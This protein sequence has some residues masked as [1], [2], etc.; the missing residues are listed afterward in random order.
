[1]IP[2]SGGGIDWHH[3]AD[4]PIFFAAQRE[5]FA[6]IINSSSTCKKNCHKMQFRFQSIADRVY[7][8][9]IDG[10]NRISSTKMLHD[11]GRWPLRHR[12][13]VRAHS[14][15]SRIPQNPGWLSSLTKIITVICPPPTPHTHTTPHLGRK[16]QYDVDD[17]IAS[18]VFPFCFISFIFDYRMNSIAEIINQGERSVWWNPINSIQ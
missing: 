18:I 13:A 11:E 17:V 10:T 14:P 3:P 5:K 6:K 4:H 12:S 9:G 2:H 1:M 16:N 15:L 8:T 7:I